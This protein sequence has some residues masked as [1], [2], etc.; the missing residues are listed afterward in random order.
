M[1]INRVP[2][3]KLVSIFLLKHF[4]FSDRATFQKSAKKSRHNEVTLVTEPSHLTKW[5][6]KPFD[7]Q[8]RLE[9]ENSPVPVS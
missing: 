3:F 5:I 8:F 6:V 4:L 9:L 2:E 1:F 7:P